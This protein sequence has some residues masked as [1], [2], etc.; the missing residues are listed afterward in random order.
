MRDREENED[1][2]L[3]MVGGTCLR[4]QE[5][6]RFLTCRLIRYNR[7]TDK[8]GHGVWQGHEI[9]QSQN[10]EQERV[11]RSKKVWLEVDTAGGLSDS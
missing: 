3:L 1:V 6:L 9:R 10:H 8:E 7:L 4:R 2:S 11:E 5:S